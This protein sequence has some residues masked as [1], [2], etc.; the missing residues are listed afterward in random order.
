MQSATPI[1]KSRL[2]SCRQCGCALDAAHPDTRQFVTGYIR[3]RSGGG[4]NQIEAMQRLQ[5]YLCERCIR[6]VK[7]G[8]SWEQPT[9]W[10]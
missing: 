5:Q 6:M 8:Q 1:P 10:D 3:R 4:T 2:V 9:L 7:Q